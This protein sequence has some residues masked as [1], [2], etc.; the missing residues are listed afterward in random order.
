MHF[1]SDL[2]IHS[3]YS[4]DSKT[5]PRD[6]IKLCAKKGINCISVS[7]HNTIRGSVATK[8]LARKIA[9]DIKVILASE[10]K[11]D[12]GDVIGYH[13][14]EDIK[15]GDFETVVDKIKQQGGYVCLAHPCDSFIKRKG[16]GEAKIKNNRR[17]ID[18]LEL[19]ARSFWFSNNEAKEL[20]K[21][22]KIPLLASSDAH[23]LKEIGSFCTILND[24][25]KLDV[26]KLELNTGKL[27]P[28]YPLA[29]TKFYKISGF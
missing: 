19:N 6:I 9:P 28:F 11:T 2:H 27:H 14:T 16:V 10:I 1:E 15:R 13:I 21:K 7:D 12:V 20:A 4:K 8:K 29:R 26:R 5:E 24:T 23:M 17:K 18:F 3:K 25:R 22:Y